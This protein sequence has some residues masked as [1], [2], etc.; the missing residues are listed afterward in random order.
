MSVGV[1]PVRMSVNYTCAWC[2]QKLEK[3]VRVPGTGVTDV[4]S[5]HLDARNPSRKPRSISSGRA[6][7]SPNC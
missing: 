6:A 7:G 4:V 2:Q 5:S 1:L 3:D